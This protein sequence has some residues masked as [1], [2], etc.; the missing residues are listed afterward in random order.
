M[1]DPRPFLPADLD[2]SKALTRAITAHFLRAVREPGASA[3]QIVDRAW[4]KDLI[5]KA[6]T[7]PI[8][9]SAAAALQPAAVA[10][11]VSGLMP[12]SGAARLMQ[13]GIR[14][15]LEGN[16]TVT[17]PRASSNPLPVFVDEG[18]PIPVP[19]AVL[20][21]ATVGPAK[22]MA[23]IEVIT[24]E[25]NDLS[26]PNAEQVIRTLM[27]EAAAKALDRGHFQHDGGK[28]VATRRHPEWRHA[29][30]GNRGRRAGGAGWRLEEPGRRAEYSRR[31]G[32][33]DGLR[34][35]GAGGDAAGLRA[36]RL[37][38]RGRAGA[39]VAGHQHG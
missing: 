27:N 8:A 10:G 9:T 23:L 29:V 37:Q 4:P 36:G 6:A 34:R 38:R 15:D 20:T 18:A 28:L 35:A 30:D 25:L 21:A 1:A 5:A 13:A 7:S 39:G 14:V 3:E 19:Q 31:R 2:A 26:T 16:G 24:G 32:A 33:G 11:F 17:I 12:I 22:K